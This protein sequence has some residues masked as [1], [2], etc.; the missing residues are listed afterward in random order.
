M[1]IGKTLRCLV[2]EN[3]GQMNKKFAPDHILR[4]NKQTGLDWRV[5][6]SEYMYCSDETDDDV[7][8]PCR[9]MDDNYCW[10]T[11]VPED[12]PEDMPNNYN[13]I[14]KIKKDIGLT[15]INIDDLMST[16][17]EAGINYWCYK[18]LVKQDDIAKYIDYDFT[19]D[20]ISL[21][22]TLILFDNDSNDTWELNLEK[23]L[24]GIKWYCE[25]NGI[26]SAEELID[27]HD[28]ETADSIVQY[29]LFDKIVFG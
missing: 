1:E 8:N 24:K 2:S 25:T 19:S 22:M 20:V 15:K 29:A 17:L 11:C 21:G 26:A 13:V 18:V 23:L 4:M 10:V 27:N 28:A 6:F 9:L 5:D 16:A 12:K 3:I 7:S 14:V